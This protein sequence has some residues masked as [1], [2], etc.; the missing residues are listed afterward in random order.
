MYRIVV[1]LTMCIIVSSCNESITSIHQNTT[2]NDCENAK[3]NKKIQRV[4]SIETLFDMT[5]DEALKWSNTPNEDRPVNGYH[6][7]HV[8]T[9]YNHNCL[10]SVVVTIEYTGAYPSTGFYYF[11]FDKNTG[12]QLGI[13]DIVNEGMAA[14]IISKYTRQVETII[15]NGRK[16]LSTREELERYNSQIEQYR[17]FNFPHRIED[18]FLTENGMVFIVPLEFPHVVQALQP[19]NIIEMPKT[20]IAP[21][22]VEGASLNLNNW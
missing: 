6:Y 17:D 3:A 22:L 4:Y 15:A 5:P 21:Y 20:D 16:N 12:A 19:N 1:L 8:D 2:S 18:F 14:P 9:T 13:F 7:Y 11:T 10:L